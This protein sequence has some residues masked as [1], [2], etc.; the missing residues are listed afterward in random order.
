MTGIAERPSTARRTFLAAHLTSRQRASLR[1]HLTGDLEKTRLLIEQLGA[2]MESFTASR[3]DA[4]TD[5]EHDPEGP[6]LAFELSQSSAILAQSI[7]HLA[8]I[9]AALYRMDEGTYGLCKTCG[10]PIALGR[11]QVRPQAPLCINCAGRLR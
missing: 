10:G 5:D 3:R 11:L 6:T 4:A 7:Q 9:D 2:D 8:D 1:N